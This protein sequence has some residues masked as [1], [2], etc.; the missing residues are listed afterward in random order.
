VIGIDVLTGRAT[1]IVVASRA[2]ARFA[3]I[4][5]VKAAK[6]LHPGLKVLDVAIIGFSM[7]TSV[8]WK[9]CGKITKDGQPENHAKI[10]NFRYQ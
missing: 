3:T 6:S 9:Y 1:D 10:G 7:M 2:A 5:A 8:A 4:S